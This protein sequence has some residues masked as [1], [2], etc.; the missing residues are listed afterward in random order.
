MAA[1]QEHECS[2]H[3]CLVCVARAACMCQ[4]CAW[5]RCR[6][7]CTHMQ[8]TRG[9]DI[10]PLSVLLYNNSSKYA[11][12]VSGAF[13]WLQVYPACLLPGCLLVG[14]AWAWQLLALVLVLA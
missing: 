4:L 2:L 7:M 12:C 9:T 3:V 14:Q 6:G 8:P 5:Q 13:F 11:A 10:L 1:A